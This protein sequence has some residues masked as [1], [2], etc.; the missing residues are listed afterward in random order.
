MVNLLFLFIKGETPI[1]IF[2]SGRPLDLAY[3]SFYS[4]SVYIIKE[5]VF[6]ISENFYLEY[7]IN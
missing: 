3:L 6:C 1:C 4:T 5:G 7:K 2:Y